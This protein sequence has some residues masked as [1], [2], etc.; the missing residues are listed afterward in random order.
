MG[1]D[2]RSPEKVQSMLNL[3]IA[4]EEGVW[5]LKCYGI[6][7]YADLSANYHGIAFWR[8]LLKG[9][10]PL[11]ECQNGKYILKRNFDIANYIDASMDESI[12]CNSYGFSKILLS[13]QSEWAKRKMKCPADETTC[14]ELRKS[15][16]P[17]VAAKIL[18]PLC[19]GTGTSQIEKS[20]DLSGQDYIDAMKILLNNKQV[21]PRQQLKTIK[22][23]K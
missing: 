15:L 17:E 5:G 8:D 20:G 6:K 10:P 1:D 22:A 9:K 4:Q 21:Q 3:G 13:L 2:S 23:T 18:H 7:S 12:N 16:P 11:I 19:L 14:A